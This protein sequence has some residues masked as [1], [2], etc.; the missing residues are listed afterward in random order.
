M[1]CA[2]GGAEDTCQGDSGG[3]MV[4]RKDEKWYIYGVTSYGF[5]CAEPEA[6]GVYVRVSA[7]VDWIL[8]NTD[9]LIVA[10]GVLDGA[11]ACMDDTGVSTDVTNSNNNPQN[12]TP[13]GASPTTEPVTTQW[14][15]TCRKQMCY[16]HYL[17]F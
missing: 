9:D 17:T 13:D 11:T 14:S 6:P 3:P 10:S 5:K 2:G 16:Y 1:V 7:Y 4:V 12:V 15:K 8:E